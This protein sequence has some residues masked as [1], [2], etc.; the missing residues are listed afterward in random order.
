MISWE[1]RKHTVCVWKMEQLQRQQLH[2]H[3]N[4]QFSIIIKLDVSCDLILF[5]VLLSAEVPKKTIQLNQYLRQCQLKVIQWKLKRLASPEFMFSNEY[6]ER[7]YLMHLFRDDMWTNQWHWSC[8]KA[9]QVLVFKFTTLRWSLFSKIN[10]LETWLCLQFPAEH[11]WVS[12]ETWHQNFITLN[13]EE[14]SHSQ[15]LLDWRFLRGQSFA[16]W[17]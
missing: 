3:S 11:C 5:N 14:L 12:R 9:P 8:T 7:S 17:E 6:K 16:L 13:K 4:V 15:I 10:L 1:E 2:K